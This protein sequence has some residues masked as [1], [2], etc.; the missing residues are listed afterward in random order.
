MAFTATLIARN[1]EG[2]KK[3]S[4]WS[5]DFDSVT[6]GVVQT[7]EIN[8]LHAHYSPGVSDKHGIVKLNVDAAA[9][10]L[11][12]AVYVSSV[13]SNDTGTLRVVCD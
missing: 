6:E 5:L 8:A 11:P 9:A 12:G 1:I 4:Y 13:T 2:N 7:G 3:V 10:A